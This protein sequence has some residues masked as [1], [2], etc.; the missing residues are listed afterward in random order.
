MEK[1][2]KVSIR[3]IMNHKTDQLPESKRAQLPSDFIDYRPNLYR[4]LSLPSYVHGYSLAIEFMKSWFLNKFPKNYFKTVHINGKHVLDDWKHFNNYNI[5]REKP[6]LAIIPTVE[7]D[8]DRENIDLYMA[9]Q[10]IL[11]KRSDFQQSFLKDYTNMNFLYLQMRALK[12]NFTFKIRVNSRAEQLD[13]F[14]RMELWFR[15]GSTMHERVSADFHI[16]Y[17]IMCNIAESVGF[18]LV[19]GRIADKDI[20][21][22][23]SY[24]NKYS[25]LPII[26]K[27]RAIN[28]KPEFFVRVKE[29]Y[30]HIACTDK[31]QLDD[32]EREGKLDTN[33]HIEFQCTLTIPIPH[34][35]VYFDQ[36][37]LIHTI[38]VSENTNNSIG[39]YSINVFEIPPQNDLGW[40][41]MAV[42]S[43]LCDKGEQSVELSPILNGEGN[44]SKVLSYSL[45]N[46]IS[47]STFLDIKVYTSDDRAKLVPIHMDYKN[48]TLYFE[49]DMEEESINIAIYADKEYVNNTIRIIEKYDESRISNNSNK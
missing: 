3:T 4:N 22:F 19:N 45:Q 5:K 20:M 31:L 40:G 1:R 41:Q 16:P 37:P 28:Q 35:F 23:L 10:N 47:P 12:M 34:F 6:M 48:S 33:F 26:Y 21:Q 27:M 9:D 32:G 49:R 15:I 13:L 25:D 39:I 14:N 24:L 46:G 43:Y 29:L 2:E 8:Y 11:L 18:T 17:D 36:K 44:I 7:Y 38:E 42:T 30:T